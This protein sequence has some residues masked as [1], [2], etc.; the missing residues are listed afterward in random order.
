MGNIL[1]IDRWDLYMR[2]III[3]GP[4]GSGKSTLVKKISE[5]YG[6]DILCW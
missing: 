3:E 1:Q 2:N 4:D 5:K 6:M